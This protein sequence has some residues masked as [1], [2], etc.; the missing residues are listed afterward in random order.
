[1]QTDIYVARMFDFLP[2]R[3]R[4]CLPLLVRSASERGALQTKMSSL[5]LPDLSTKAC[6]STFVFCGSR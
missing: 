2:L 1:M 5:M 4:V 6:F 3:R